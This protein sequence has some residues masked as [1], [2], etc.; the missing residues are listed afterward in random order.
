M[1]RREH[2]LPS[3]SATS[4]ASPSPAQCL[5][6]NVPSPRIDLRL[7]LLAQDLGDRAQLHVGRSLV[8]RTDLAVTV[9]LLLR[10]VLGETDATHPVDALDGRPLGHLRGVILGHG[11]L[12]QERY[13]GL[14]QSG[15]IVHQQPGGLDL[16][17]HR[18][19][20]V[21][22]T[23]ERVQ[24]RTELFALQQVRDGGIEAALRQPDH[25]CSDTD[26]ALVQETGRVLIAL[27]ELAQNVLLRN[28]HIIHMERAG[29]GSAD[30]ELALA[31]A[32]GE[33]LVLAL[34]DERRDATVTGRRIRIGHNQEHTGQVR[35]GDPHL[36]P[37]QHV[38]VTVLFRRRLQRE[39][40]RSGRRFR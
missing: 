5:R 25:L 22:H 28:A 21:L 2:S 36:C 26:A 23:L 3:L 37:V 35:V 17:R 40:I 7:V 34:H 33:A 24:I 20:L 4:L 30:T 16:R 10:E 18:G 11:G 29:T 32:H 13:T 27:A 12:L 14:L 19:N 8:D 6:A 1:L 15:S 9:E 39:R 38:M 31:L